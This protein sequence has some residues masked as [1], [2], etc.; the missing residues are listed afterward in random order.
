MFSNPEGSKLKCTVKSNEGL[1][2]QT[3]CL[4]EI[5]PGLPSGN[6]S[7]GGG[8]GADG[9]PAYNVHGWV[10]GMGENPNTVSHLTNK[11]VFPLLGTQKKTAEVVVNTPRNP[12]KTI[13]TLCTT[14]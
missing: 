11:H 2:D 9:R 6:V 13:Q 5:S 14:K 12:P 3:C 10:P 8:S 1:L 7:G 4:K